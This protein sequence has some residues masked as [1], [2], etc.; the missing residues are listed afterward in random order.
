MGEGNKG[1]GYTKYFYTLE[2]IAKVS[3]TEVNTIRQH[4][5]RQKIDPTRLE[6]VLEYIIN[7]REKN[8]GSI[9]DIGLP[10]I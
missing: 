2:D 4:M 7:R 3:G 9:G 1:K 10:S 8:G 6:S 5:L